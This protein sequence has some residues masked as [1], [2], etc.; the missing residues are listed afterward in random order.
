[1]RPIDLIIDSIPVERAFRDP[2]EIVRI[3]RHFPVA[4]LSAKIIKYRKEI[5]HR[6]IYHYIP[7]CPFFEE[8]P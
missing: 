8:K 7:P 2:S 5:G 6:P 3:I 1:M 4:I